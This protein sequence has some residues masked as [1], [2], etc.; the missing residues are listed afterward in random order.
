MTQTIEL[1]AWSP[2]TMALPANVALPLAQTDLLDVQIADAAASRWRLVPNSRIGVAI[3]PGWELRIRPR[4]AI[5][6][7][8]FL[9]G[10]ASDP[11]GWRELG[12]LFEVD[13]DLLGAIAH[14]FAAQAERV[15]ARGPIRG[16]VTVNDEC[17]TLR[18]HLRVNDQIARHPGLLIPLEVAYDDYLLDVPE[19][20]MIRGAAEL[21]LQLPRVHGLVRR[22]LLRIRETL[23][24]ATPALPSPAIETPPITR[25]NAHHSGVL[26][27]SA[28]ILR[29]RSI[30]TRRGSV[31]AT[32]F[33]FDMNQIFE[34]FLSVSLRKALEAYGG[35]VRLQDAR[36]TL[37][38]G[39]K[40]RLKPDITWW[41]EGTCRAV[42]DAKYKRLES[43]STP[44]ADVYQ[45]LAYCTALKLQRGYLVYAKDGSQSSGSHT[46]RNTGVQVAVRAIDVEQL[47]DVLLCEI[48]ALARSI[49]GEKA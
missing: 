26:A 21:L 24:D 28:L 1:E 18:G 22:R 10:Y 48:N 31:V 41:Q 34:D 38:L 14:G 32:A 4:L 19:N 3:G 46:V 25:L 6:R 11:N 9:L 7:L 37:D 36:A 45:M 15:L 27:L 39:A 13:Q 42:V 49:A 43:A 29:S 35:R 47:P 5:P 44:N 33:T 8:M 12:P 16:Y 2:E 17:L 23:A 20:R 30:A 40:I